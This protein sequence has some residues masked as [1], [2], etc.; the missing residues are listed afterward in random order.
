MH[1][2]EATQ[3]FVRAVLVVIDQ[4]LI[5]NRLDLL[6]VG[7]QVR[8]ENLGSISS[9]EALNEGVL[10]WFAGLDIADRD[11]LCASPFGKGL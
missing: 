11:A 7:E 2:R 8:V 9:I 6:K 10:I 1:W 5:G 4:P 3:R